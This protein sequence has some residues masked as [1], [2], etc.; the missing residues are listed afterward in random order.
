MSKIDDKTMSAGDRVRKR[1]LG[2]MGTVTRISDP[3]WVSVR[4]DDG[5]EAKVRPRLCTAE[6]LEPA[7]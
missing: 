3:G 7:P 6:E 2:H 1:G 4:W 5:P